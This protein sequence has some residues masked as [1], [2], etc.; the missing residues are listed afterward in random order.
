MNWTPSGAQLITLYTT[1]FSGNRSWTPVST[2]V[3][4]ILSNLKPGTYSIAIVTFYYYTVWFGRGY[5][6][7][8]AA[9]DDIHLNVT[10]EDYVWSGSI[11]KIVDKL[12]AYRVGVKLNSVSIN[13]YV[14]ILSLYIRNGRYITTSISIVD[15]SITNNE[16]TYIVFNSTDVLTANGTINAEVSVTNNTVVNL[17]LELAYYSPITSRAVI[18]HYPLIINITTSST[19]SI[20]PPRVEVKEKPLHIPIK[21]PP[22]Q[23]KPP[24]LIEAITIDSLWSK[25][26]PYIRFIVD[27]ELIEEQ[28]NLNTTNTGHQ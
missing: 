19:A 24:R 12:G 18:V 6:D 3:T 16:T 9:F 2:D 22:T 20:T 27:R 7:M 25:Y 26:F 13:G 21:P 15:N 1:S 17:S 28:C 4:T 8:Y 23:S 10:C 5:A 11:W 14:N